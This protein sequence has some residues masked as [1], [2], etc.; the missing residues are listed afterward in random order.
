MDV[1]DKICVIGSNGML[2]HAVVSELERCGYTNILKIDRAEIDLRNQNATEE[3]F[4]TEKPVGVFFLAAVAAGIN[5]KK[6]HPVEMLLDNLQMVINV[7][8]SAHESRVKK[9]INICSALVYPK[10]VAIPLKE[11]DTTMID[12][13]N[14][15]TP[16]ALAKG[17]G[18]KLSQYYR[19]EFGDNFISAVPCNFF[20][21]YAP[22]EGDRAGVVPSLISRITKAKENGDKRVEVWG[23]GNACRELLNSKDVASACIFLLENDIPYDFMNIGRG[24]EYSIRE[25]AET[26]KSVVGYDGELFFDDT[27]PEGRMHMQLNVDRLFGMG[28]RP[29]MNLEDSIKD[30]FKWYV[31]NK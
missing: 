11:E 4:L 29:S 28:W 12:I 1:K 15:D 5:Y 31:N 19:Q 7:L 27:K 24:E 16:Y 26:I 17:V 21:E 6:S 8:S 23:T 18:I 2:G 30:A 10:T 13:N 3:L 22:F 20:G 14:V 9:L 25:V